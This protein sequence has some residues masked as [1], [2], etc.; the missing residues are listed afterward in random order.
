MLKK[1]DEDDN[2]I[3]YGLYDLYSVYNNYKKLHEAYFGNVGKLKRREQ[4]LAR[5]KYVL[6]HGLKQKDE[7]ET[8][9]WVLDMEDVSE[10]EELCREEKKGK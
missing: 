5:A 7:L 10:L 9:I 8:L 6:K 2:G 4:I 3:K 1:W